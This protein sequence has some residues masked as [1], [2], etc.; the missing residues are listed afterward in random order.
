VQF[1]RYVQD[2]AVA[3][4]SGDAGFGAGDA[5]CDLRGPAGQHLRKAPVLDITP[6]PQPLGDGTPRPSGQDGKGYLSGA[7]SAQQRPDRARVFRGRPICSGHQ[8][9]TRAEGSA[10]KRETHKPVSYTHLTLPTKA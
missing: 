4:R 6:Q 2:L 9:D 1:S 3:D 8:R 5:G 10:S 7:G